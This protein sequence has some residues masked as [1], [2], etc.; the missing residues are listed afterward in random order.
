MTDRNDI[1]PNANGWRRLSYTC[2]CGWVD[3]GHAL[4]DGAQA[5]RTQIANE[6]AGWP[7]LD[8][9]EVFLEGEPAYAM[10]YGQE[11]GGRMPG[12]PPIVVSAARH[13][14][15]RRN[16][17]Q[18]QRE[19]VGLAIFLSASFD[20]ERLQG[21]FPFSIVSGHSSFSPEDLVSNLIGFFSAYR[22]IPQPQMRQV[23]GEVSVAESYRLWDAH[24]P[25]GFDGLRNRTTRP[26]LFPSRECGTA[27]SN[28][29][30]PAL[31][32]SIT[33]VDRGILWTRLRERF[34]DGAI[35]NAGRAI[36]VSS[37]GRISLR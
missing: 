27:S 28:T 29:V 8:R 14:V 32:S 23:C 36:D 31:F 4:P 33:P 24:L 22:S 37:D 7:G 3:W 9:L 34:I 15:V 20:F 1:Q 16:L 18:V 12:L 26:I 30:F 11:M 10:W 2:R 35:V 5:L 19:R 6:R 13:W 17:T 21:A 25:N